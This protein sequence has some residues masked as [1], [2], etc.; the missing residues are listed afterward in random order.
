MP[1]KRDDS[2][3]P[4]W[5]AS[6]FGGFYAPLYTQVPDVLFDEVMVYLTGAELK[7]L[8]YIVRRT[9]GFKKEADAIGL[10]QLTGGIVSRAGVRQDRGTG[11]ARSTVLEALRS[12]KNKGL[13]ESEE[14]RVTPIGSAPTVYRLRMAEGVPEERTPGVRSYDRGVPQERTP[15]SH[16]SGTTRNTIPRNIPRDRTTHPQETA[17]KRDRYGN[18]VHCGTNQCPADCPVQAW[19]PRSA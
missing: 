8:L 15:R 18:C 3:L 7:C 11:L 9:F 10:D 14:Q 19:P 5:D 6:Q 2:S 12:L 17:R 4:P 1:R 16:S 13:I